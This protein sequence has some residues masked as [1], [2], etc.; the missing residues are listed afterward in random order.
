[1]NEIRYS[2]HPASFY[3]FEFENETVG[4]GTG[5]AISVPGL[6]NIAWLT[7]PD[8]DDYEKT[9]LDV[10]SLGTWT[11]EFAKPFIETC[12][13][14]L[15]GTPIGT[16]ARIMTA[17]GLTDYLISHKDRKKT[18]CYIAFGDRWLPYIQMR[19]FRSVDFIKA[20]D[21]PDAEAKERPTFG[22]PRLPK[23]ERQTLIK[24]EV[25]DFEKWVNK[26][27]QSSS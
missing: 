15:S 25:R 6:F 3:T 5:P 16:L 26:L 27:K 1:M 18:P 19:S 7:L 17:Q 8:F 4:L 23:F 21:T 9:P 20:A 14:E 10:D 13:F 22:P 11:T 24:G 2:P 12:R